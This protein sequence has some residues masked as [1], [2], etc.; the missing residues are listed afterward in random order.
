[1]KILSGDP[2]WRNLTAL[3]YHFLTQPLPNVIGWYVYHLP[4]WMH[5]AMVAGTFV[6]ELAVPFLIFAPRRLR[7]LAAGLFTLLHLQIFITGNYNFFN[8][9]AIVLCILLFDDAVLRRLPARLRQ[10]LTPSTA[11]HPRRVP[12]W[13][14]IA[15]AVVLIVL[16]SFQLAELFG[17]PTPGA[18][19]ELGQLL[20]PLRV[21]N[22][23]GPFAVMTTTRPEIVVEGSNDGVMW[24]EYQFKYKPGDV[25]RAPPLVEPHQP[26]LDW[27]MWFAALGAN[28][29]DPNS[30][31][32]ELR[33]GSSAQVY[34]QNYGA[35][36]WF[37]NFAVRL[38]EGSPQVLALMDT[39]PFPN[40]PPKFIRARLYE[41]HFTDLG[42]PFS[43]GDW[44]TRTELGTYLPAFS[45]GG[46]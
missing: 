8:L 3:D 43:S 40:A 16:S 4:S 10:F 36:V 28:T 2:N 30:L 11:A 44:W 1:V 21:V 34:S 15:I 23:Y 29:T 6:I 25:R 18:I 9:L 31:L 46:E 12:Y 35:D 42:A 19:A 41:Y 45:L 37:L 5:Q 7:F 20:S 26:R 27:Q 39:N 22:T 38:L 33:N 17:V 24:V 32:P 14:A 13:I